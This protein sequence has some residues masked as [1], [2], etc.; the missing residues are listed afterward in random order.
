MKFSL[1]RSALVLAASLSLASCG[2]GGKATFPIT[3]TV[4]NLTEPGLVLSTNGMDLPVTPATAPATTT[5]VTFP[6]QL[7]YGQAYS[8]IPKGAT[9]SGNALTSYGTQPAH[10]TCQPSQQ[11]PHNLLVYGTAGQL[12]SIQIYYDC[13]VNGYSLGG[14]ITGLTADG[15][16]LANGNIDSLAV[17]AN[18]TAFTMPNQVPY[19]TTFGVSVLT[20]PTGLTCS[21]SGG[22]GSANNGS[23]IMDDAAS[24]VGGVNNLVVSCVP[25]S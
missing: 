15:L 12:A 20:Q 10:Q 8:V 7:D 13:T 16:V 3:V 5:T 1:A 6:N 18:S 2:G 9:L 23:G 19:N 21:V 22:N 25:N 14:S 4:S 24:K 17:P 11:Y